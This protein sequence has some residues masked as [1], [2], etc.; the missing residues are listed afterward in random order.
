MG[1][2]FGLGF[3]VFSWFPDTLGF[4]K[5]KPPEFQQIVKRGS[6]TVKIYRTPSHGCDSFT[7]SYYQDGVRKRPTFPTYQKAKTEAEAVASRLG[8]TD[9]DILTLTSADRA[10]YLR[11]RQ[12]LDAVGVPLEAAAAQ[13][14]AAKSALGDTPLSHAVEFYIKRH[15][16]K[17]AP[18]RVQDVVA[19]F[20]AA[21][22]ADGV[23]NACAIAWASSRSSSGATSGR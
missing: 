18:K 4:V 7:L 11:A 21:K 20:M 13:F 2:I 16:T 17:I 22:K 12:I 19:E 8:N 6:V 5:A 9:S 10:A 1:T 3:G 15:P 23:S 14:A